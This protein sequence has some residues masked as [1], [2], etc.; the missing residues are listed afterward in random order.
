MKISNQAISIKTILFTI[1]SGIVI[2]S[3][4]YYDKEDYLYPNGNLDCKDTASTSLTYT[5]GI[6]TIID[7]NCA[8]PGCHVSGGTSPD[9]TT[10]S[11]V[12]TNTIRITARAITIKDMPKPSGMSVCNIAKLDNWIKR[13]ALEN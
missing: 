13:G 1:L 10:Y 9:L 8:S 11:L 7:G 4:C 12:K 6:K 3:G 5:N 2:L